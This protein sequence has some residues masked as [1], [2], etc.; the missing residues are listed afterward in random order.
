M[1]VLG[2][3]FRQ[4]LDLPSRFFFFSFYV[5]VPEC[6]YVYHMHVV[7]EEARR[8]RQPPRELELPFHKAAV[9]RH[10]DSG[11]QLGLSARAVPLT[12]KP[13]LQSPVLETPA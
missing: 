13:S 7:P 12:D 1:S 11:A 5:S 9:T 3:L 2:G 10:M 8:G 4:A 6:V